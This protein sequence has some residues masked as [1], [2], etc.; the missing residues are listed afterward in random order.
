V[1]EDMASLANT[2]GNDSYS[3]AVHAADLH[4]G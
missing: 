1:F 3:L 2:P 4:S